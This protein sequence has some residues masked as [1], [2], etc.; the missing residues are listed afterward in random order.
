MVQCYVPKGARAEARGQ[1]SSGEPGGGGGGYGMPRF[2]GKPLPSPRPAR[3]RTP[4]R[5]PG[6]N[7]PP[8]GQRIAPLGRL[9]HPSTPSSPSTPNHEHTVEYDGQEWLAVLVPCYLGP[10]VRVLLTSVHLRLILRDA[11]KYAEM[12]CIQTP[13]A[14][15]A[16]DVVLVVGCDTARLVFGPTPP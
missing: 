13:V 1:G 7:S 14:T 10:L 3:R 12:S 2:W 6:A 5:T 8:G 16:P 4:G 11:Q 9:S 15:L